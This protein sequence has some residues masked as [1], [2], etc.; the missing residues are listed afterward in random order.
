MD[1]WFRANKLSLNVKKTNYSI[2]SPTKVP[3]DV[4]RTLILSNTSINRVRCLEHRSTTNMEYSQKNKLKSKIA[5]SM[6]I[7][8]RVKKQLPHNALKSIYLTLVHSH[9]IYGITAWGNSTTTNKS[10][11]LQQR[12]LRLINNKTYVSHTDPLFKQEN[13]LKLHDIYKVI[14]A[15]HV[16]DILTNNLPSSFNNFF[17]IINPTQH[18]IITRQNNNLPQTLTRTQFSARTTYHVIPSLLWNN[19][20]V[21]IRTIP[22][23]KSLKDKLTQHIMTQYKSKVICKYPR[24]PDCKT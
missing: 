21:S 2:F 9:L 13:V 18:D 20:E 14:T 17:P 12:A 7:L 15:L 22:S 5:N 19:L 4:S 24:C 10:Y 8:N 1:A 16:H 6:F 11:L 3:H 23:R